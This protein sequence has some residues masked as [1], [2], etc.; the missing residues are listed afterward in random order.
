[1]RCLRIPNGSSRTLWLQSYFADAGDLE[2]RDSWRLILDS[3][4]SF[5]AVH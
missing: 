1:M 2:T 4:L 3:L 5:L